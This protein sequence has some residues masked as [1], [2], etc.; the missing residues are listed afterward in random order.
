LFDYYR[1]PYQV[2]GTLRSV[3]TRVLVSLDREAAPYVI[4]REKVYE[5]GTT[6]SAAVWVTNDHPGPIDGAEVAWALTPLRG[7]AT[8]GANSLKL[9]LPADASAKVDHISWAIPQ[10]ARPGAYRVRMRVLGPDGEL[11]SSNHTDISVR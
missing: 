10:T 3:Y 6:F 1:R 2:C 11:L 8:V 4:G 5:R 7:E 9:T